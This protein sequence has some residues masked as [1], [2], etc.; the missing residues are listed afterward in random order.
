MAT[1]DSTVGGTSP[2][3]A[4][5]T[6]WEADRDGLSTT[7]DTE[8]A[9]VRNV[10]LDDNLVI[11]G[12]ASGV[13]VEVTHDTGARHDGSSGSGARI[14]ASSGDA[15]TC[16][17]DGITVRLNGIEVSAETN[18]YEINNGNA[19]GQVHEIFNCLIHSCTD[20][21]FIN[22]PNTA[23]ATL[24][25]AYTSI[26]NCV[27]QS[28]NYVSFISQSTTTVIEMWKCAIG[29]QEIRLRGG[30][31]TVGAQLYARA[32][33]IHSIREGDA[34][35]EWH[36]VD[37]IFNETPFVG[38]D[39]DTNNLTGVTWVTGD[40]GTGEVGVTDVDGGDYHLVDD[41]DNVAINHADG[42]NAFAWVAEV[43][44]DDDAVPVTGTDNVDVGPDQLAS[45]L[46]DVTITPDAIVAV[47]TTTTPTVTRGSFTITPAVARVVARTTDATVTRGSLTVSPAAA[48]VVATT[49]TPSVVRGSLTITPTAARAVAVTTTPGVDITGGGVTVTP[50]AMRVVATTTT[51]TVTLGSFTVTVGAAR[52]VASTTTPS[53]SLGSLTVS[54][55]VIRA[56]AVTTTPDAIRGSFTITPLVAR[57]VVTVTTP[58]IT[59]GSVTI[60]PGAIRA[61]ATTPTPTLVLGSLTI[62]PSVIRVIAGSPAI[63]ATVGDV[64]QPKRLLE[65]S[66]VYDMQK[67]MLGIK[68]SS[69]IIGSKIATRSI[70]G[71]F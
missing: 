19:V 70:T 27:A 33:L 5:L 58:S 28:I 3:Y 57:A 69:S 8:R 18:G 52:A 15:I 62:T 31:G 10:S 56:V 14:N 34:N 49:T 38:L 63:T 68:K 35:V 64:V 55:A 32:C 30:S 45:E 2:D 40:P 20:G 44:W 6:L 59:L 23:P 42:A 37:S 26:F 13:V 12:W 41:A 61:A 60:S 47:A 53:M 29:D 21:I 50:G 71:G 17:Q 9:L 54:P 39:T 25:L 16:D 46:S 51:P 67:T 36:I 11:S 4:T 48:R 7:G 43:D 22:G 65:I 24:R 1:V 66:A